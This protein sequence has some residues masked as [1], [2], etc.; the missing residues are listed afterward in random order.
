MAKQPNAALAALLR[1]VGW[2]ESRLAREV[3]RV[4]TEA[5]TRL[6]YAQPSVS[7]WLAGSVPRE[8]VRPLIREAFARGLGRPVTYADMGFP[9]PTGEPNAC[10]DILEELVDLGRRDMD[11]S[12]RTTLQASLYS[13]TIAIPGMDD[14]AGRAEFVQSGKVRRIGIS[15]VEVVTTMTA[16]FSDMDHKFGGRHARPAAAAFLVDTVAPY[17]RAQGPE[18][19]RKEMFSAASSLCYFTGYMAADDEL[20]GLAQ[21]Y[22]LK[23]LELAGVAG[24]RAAYSATLRTMSRQALMLDHGEQAMRLADAAADD[25]RRLESRMRAFIAGGQAAAAAQIGDRRAA[26]AHFQEADTALGKAGPAER[27]Y[28]AY[29]PTGHM[30]VL[31]YVK[32]YAKD[33]AGAID[34]LKKMDR[35]RPQVRRRDR[36]VDN[37]HLAE[38]LYEAGHLE[39]A[40]ATWGAVLDDYP[41]AR[42]GGSDK[43]MSTMLSRIGPHLGNRTARALAERART[44]VP[45][46]L[47]PRQDRKPRAVR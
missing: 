5:R 10:A 8:Q 22:W 9:A 14:L 23:S 32:Y 44:V 41:L 43:A 15:D 40:C 35:L 27:L 36:V 17:L 16:Q 25:S 42:S 4:G 6:R 47:W 12:R 3:N 19:V 11:P 30:H 28:G 26:L 37:S 46:S 20:H 1:A 13:L 34:S 39:E 29:S 33:V 31:S 38:R 45:P 24:D 7:H 21:K 18:E 2:S